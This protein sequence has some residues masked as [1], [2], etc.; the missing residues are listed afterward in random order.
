[1]LAYEQ[2]VEY[3]RRLAERLQPHDDK[4]RAKLA[5]ET[6]RLTALER[7]VAENSWAANENR[8]LAP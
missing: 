1:L 3:R 4:L 2:G 5:Q 8:V 7:Q 6:A